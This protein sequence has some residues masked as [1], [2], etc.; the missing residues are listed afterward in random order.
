MRSSL[1]CTKPNVAELLCRTAQRWNHLWYS[2]PPCQSY[3]PLWCVVQAACEAHVASNSGLL[4]ST[5]RTGCINFHKRHRKSVQTHLLAEA[6]FGLC[7][8]NTP[9]EGEHSISALEKQPMNTAAQVD[10]EHANPPGAA[11]TGT[12][13]FKEHYCESLSL[14]NTHAKLAEPSNKAILTTPLL[15]SPAWCFLCSAGTRFCVPA[16]CAGCRNW[17]S[18]RKELCFRWWVLPWINSY[19]PQT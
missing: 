10:E 4:S 12:P 2:D 18:W 19:H 16:Q 15:S 6:G 13:E 1:I 3:N 8:R 7:H 14:T 5:A 11:S 17:S 9:S